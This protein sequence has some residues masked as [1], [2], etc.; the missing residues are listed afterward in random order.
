MLYLNRRKNESWGA[1][2]ILSIYVYLLWGW[3]QWELSNILVKCLEDLGIKPKP[4]EVSCKSCCALLGAVSC[5]VCG[6]QWNIP[7]G[8]AGSTQCC[9]LPW[10]RAGAWLASSASYP[11][12]GKS[13]LGRCQ[14]RDVAVPPSHACSTIAMVPAPWVG[15]GRAWNVLASAAPPQELQSQGDDV[16]GSVWHKVLELSFQSWLGTQG[17][18]GSYT[19]TYGMSW[20]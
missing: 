11:A 4:A 15:A 14:G 16:S 6:L 9:P 10:A 13:L 17:C 18:Q 5:T 7:L 1:L 3:R 2:L 19:F 8:K 20:H 12:S